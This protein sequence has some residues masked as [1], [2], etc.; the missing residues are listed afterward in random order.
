MIREALRKKTRQW[1]F[2]LFPE[3]DPGEECFGNRL[4]NLNLSLAALRSTIERL[5]EPPR[6][7]PRV[8]TVVLL[9][10]PKPVEPLPTERV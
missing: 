6:P 2:E 9:M 5:T 1:F 8:A 10:D 3:F 4:V 7:P